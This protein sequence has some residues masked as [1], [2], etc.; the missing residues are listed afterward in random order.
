MSWPWYVAYRNPPFGCR[1]NA[2]RFDELISLHQV[3]SSRLIAS[4]QGFWLWATAEEM[5]K[6]YL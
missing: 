2:A 4:S 3:T 5:A 1:S 6:G